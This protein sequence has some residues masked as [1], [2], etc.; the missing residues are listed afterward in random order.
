MSVEGYN[1]ET[2]SPERLYQDAGTET[3][4]NSYTNVGTSI[5][6]DVIQIPIN[7]TQQFQLVKISTSDYLTLCEVEIFAG[8]I[9]MYNIH[10]VC[11]NIYIFSK[12]TRITQ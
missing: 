8:I 6:A 9:Q 4:C 7:N 1:S 10:M 12:S 2:G 11:I 3:S 5:C